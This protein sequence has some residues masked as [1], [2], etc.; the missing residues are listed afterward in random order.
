[1]MTPEEFHPW[2]QRLQFSKE[3]EAL[4]A[5]MRPSSPVRHVTGRTSN[6]T[7]RYRSSKCS[8]PS[9]LKVNM[10]NCGRSMGWN[11]TMMCWSFT[12]KRH[13]YHSAITPNQAVR[14]HNGTCLTSSSEKSRQA[15][16]SGSPL[17]AVSRGLWTAPHGKAVMARQQLL[18]LS[19]VYDPW[20]ADRMV[21]VQRDMI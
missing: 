2:S 1:M 4:I 16:K 8:A 5:A 19:P 15:G 17:S 6:V 10:S 18:F 14:P 12:T 9:S 21:L 20:L 7:G 13:A 11:G 3:T